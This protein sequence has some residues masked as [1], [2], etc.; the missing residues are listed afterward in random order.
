MRH[1]P[2]RPRRKLVLRQLEERLLFTAV[3]FLSPD[4]LDVGGDADGAQPESFD[5]ADDL[6]TEQLDADPA[7]EDVESLPAEALRREVVIVDSNVSDYAALLTQLGE[8]PSRELLLLVLDDRSD[9][10]DQI[11]SFLSGQSDLDA[12]H[13][14][15]HGNDAKLRLGDAIITSENL[16]AYAGSLAGWSGSLATDADILL[17]GCDVAATAAGQALAQSIAALT[18]ADVAASND[19]TGHLSL[20]GD[21]TLEY[22]TGS[23]EATIAPS[24]AAQ[25]AFMHVLAD[26]DPSVTVA[27]TGGTQPGASATINL[28][29]DNTGLP[30]DTGF[31]PFIDVLIPKL[32]ADGIY[33]GDLTGDASLY[34]LSDVAPA[35]GQ[36]DGQPDGLILPSGLTVTYQGLELT[37]FL[38]TFGDDD[39]VGAGTTGTIAHPYAVDSS[40]TPLNVVGQAGDQLLVIEL[41]FGSFAADQPVVDITIDAPISPLADLGTPLTVFA[42]GGFRYGNDALADPTSDPTLLSDAGT[43]PTTWTASDSVIP[44]SLLVTK[45]TTASGEGVT[46]PNWLQ[47]FTIDVDIPT[48]QMLSNFVLTDALPDN[49]QFSQI[50][51]VSVGGALNAG[52]NFTTNANDT[53]GTTNYYGQNEIAGGAGV[54]YDAALVGT[55]GTIDP[56]G[57]QAGK[58]LA[59]VADSG[60]TGYDGTDITVTVTYFVPDKDAAG[61]WVIGGNAANADK[62][63]DDPNSPEISNTATVTGSIAAVDARDTGGPVSENDTVTLDTKSISLQKSVSVVGGGSPA[64]GKLLEW[65]LSFELSDYYTY[66]NLVIDDL[67]SDGQAYFSDATNKASFSVTDRGGPP[68]FADFAFAYGSVAAAF[69]GTNTLVVDE[70]RHDIGDGGPG[71]PTAGEVDNTGSDGQT[72]I[73]IFLSEAL[74]ALGDDGILEGDLADNGVFDGQTATGTIT[75]YTEIQEEFIDPVAGQDRSVDQG[76]TLTNAATLTADNHVNR[77]DNVLMPASGHA[78]ADAAS[79]STTIPVGTLTKQLFAINGDTGISGELN[80]SAGDRVTYRLTYNLPTTDFEDLVLTDF[81]PLPVFDVADPDADGYSPLDPN[82]AWVFD[83][84]TSTTN[85]GA[86]VVE[87]L[88]SDTFYDV[89][90][91]ADGGGLDDSAAPTVSVDAS[92]NSLSV[93]FGTFDGTLNGQTQIDLLVTVT[94]GDT[95]FADGLFLT[96]MAL[97]GEASTSGSPSSNVDL[98]QIQLSAPELQITKGIVSTS[99]DGVAVYSTSAA[100]NELQVITGA[101]GGPF[102]LTF[103]GETTAAVSATA[104]AEEIRLALEGLSNV[105]AGDVIVTGSSIGSGSM[106]LAFIGQYEATDISLS[107]SDGGLTATQGI[108]GGSPITAA[109]QA[110]IWGLPGASANTGLIDAALLAALPLDND[111]E[112]LDA[113]DQIKY[114]VTVRNV[115]GGDAYDISITD[116]LPAGLE[117]AAGGLNLHVYDVAGN[118]LTWTALGADP[119]AD[120]IRINDPIAVYAW[121]DDGFDRLVTMDSR[122]NFDG[123][124]NAAFV[125]A[126]PSGIGSIEAMA[127][128]PSTGTLYGIDE[129]YLG[130]IDLTTGAFTPFADRIDTDIS[131]TISDAD[132][133]SFHPVTG[134]LWAVDSSG[135]ELVKIDVTTGKAIVGAFGGVDSLT[136][137]G[138]GLDDIA[139]DF[140]GTIFASSASVLEILTVDESTGT[141]TRSPVGNFMYGATSLDDMEGISVDQ[142]GRL[143]GTTGNNDSSTYDDR[144]WEI[145][146]ATGA[147]SNPRALSAGGDFESVVAF[148][149]NASGSATRAGYDRDTLVITYDLQLAASAEPVDEVTPGVLQLGQYDNDANLVAYS[150][151]D[152]GDDFVPNDAAAP[153]DSASVTMTDISLDTFI[154]DSSE[155]HTGLDALGQTEATIGEIIR[156]RVEMVLPEGTLADVTLRDVLPSGLTF[157]DDGTAEIAFVSDNDAITSTTIAD[158][159][160]FI[161]GN[162]TTIATITPVGTFGDEDVANSINGSTDTYNSGTDVYFKLGDIVNLDDDANVEYVVIEF[163]ALVNNSTVNNSGTSLTHQVRVYVDDVSHQLSIAG[164]DDRVRIVEP[165]LTLGHTTSTSSPDAGDII[166]V[167]STLVNVGGTYGANAFDVVFRDDLPAGFTRTGVITITDSLSNAVVA[168]VDSSST[169]QIALTFDQLIEGETYTITY[170]VVANTDI[171]P[172]TGYDFDADLTWTSLSGVDGTNP[173][174]TGSAT[175]GAAGSSTGERTGSESPALN[176]YHLTDTETVDT[177]SLVFTK[178]LIGTE[179]AND[180]DGDATDDQAVIGEIVTYRLQ[181][182]VPEGEATGLVIVDTLDAGLAFVGLT[183]VTV[184]DDLAHVGGAP[185]TSSSITTTVGGGGQSLTF[186]IGDVLDP[187]PISSNDIDEIWIEYQA[188][189][190]NVAGNQGAPSETNTLL[191]NSATLSY[192]TGS[193][194]TV[195]AL[196]VEVIEPELTTTL[197]VYGSGGSGDTLIEAGEAI[198]AEYTIRNAS[199]VDAFDVYSFLDLIRVDDGSTGI[200]N[201]STPGTA[202]AFTVVDT[203]GFYNASHFEWVDPDNTA[204][205]GSDA[206]GWRLQ[207]INPDGFDLAGIDPARTITITVTGTASD[208]VDAGETYTTDVGASFTSIDGA[209]IDRSTYNTNSD[210]RSFDSTLTI[211]YDDYQA[212]SSSNITM[213]EPSISKTL[214]TT[215]INA[216]GNNHSQ[217]TIGELLTYTVEVTLPQGMTNN[218]VVTDVMD[219]GLS[220]VGMVSGLAP[221][222]VAADGKTLTWNL[223]TLTN[224]PAIGPDDTVTLVYQAVVLDVAAN[225]GG[226]QIG[227]SAA[228]QVTLDFDLPDSSPGPQ[229]SDDTS[230]QVVTVVEPT[231]TLTRDTYVNNT[232]GNT[233]GDAGDPVKFV[234]ELA[235]TSGV[236]AFDLQLADV[237]PIVIGGSS[238]AIISPTFTVTDTDLTYTSADFELVGSN[239]SGW[240]F[241]KK[242][243]TDFDLISSVTRTITI[244]ID[245]T[246]ANVVPGGG[247]ISDDATVTWTSLDGDFGGARSGYS[248]DSIERDGSDTEAG[249]PNDYER[250]RSDSVTVTAIPP[251]KIVQSTSLGSSG[252]GQHNVANEDLAIGETITYSLSYTFSEGLT[253]SA[254]LIDVAG[255]TTKLDILNVVVVGVGTNLYGAGVDLEDNGDDTLLSVAGVQSAVSITDSNTDTYLDTVTINLSNV[256]NTPDGVLDADDVIT[257]EVTARVA[258]DLVNADGAVLTNKAQFKFLDADSGFTTDRTLESATVSADVITHDLTLSKNIVETKADAGEQV[259]I[260]L[261]VQNTGTADAH[262]VDIRD[263]LASAAYDLTSVLLGVA[264]T[265][266]PA[267]FTANMNAGSGDLTYTGGT[268]AAGDTVTFT[269]LVDVADSAAPGDT[270]SNLSTITDSSSLTAAHADQAEARTQSDADGVDNSALD[271]T[272]SFA[273]RENTISGFVYH[274]ADMSDTFNAGDVGLAGVTMTLTGTDHL[275]NAITPIVITTASGAGVDPLGYYLFDKLRPGSYTLTQT[276]PATHLDGNET[277]G[278]AGTLAGASPVHDVLTFSLPTGTET[279]SLGNDFGEITKAVITGYVHRDTDLNGDYGGSGGIQDVTVTINY[280][281]DRNI[282]ASQSISTDADGRFVFGDLRPGTYT[283]TVDSGDA[284]LAGYLNGIERDDHNGADSTTDY[285]IGSFAVAQGESEDDKW[286]GFHLPTS[287]AGYVYHDEDNDGVKDVGELG[288]IGAQMRLTGTTFEGDVITAAFD[289]TDASGYYEFTNLMPGTYNVLEQIAPIG[290]LD[291]RDTAGDP[292]ANTTTAHLIN[293]IVLSDGEDSTG[294]LFGHVLASSLAGTVFNDFDSDGIQDAGEPGIESVTVTLSGN[295]ELPDGSTAAITPIIVSTAANGTYSFTNLRPGVYTITETQPA[296]YADGTDAAGTL[297]GNTAV[298]EVISSIVVTSDDHGAG[299]NFA[300]TGASITGT[301]FRDDDRDGTLDGGEPGI[302]GATIELYESDGTT[303]ITTTTTAA[304]GTY[305]FDDLAAGDYVVKEIQPTLYTSSPATDTNTRN[306]TLVTG[307]DNTGNNFGEELWDLDGRVWFDRD[308]GADNDAGEDGFDAVTVTLLYAGADGDLATSGDNVTYTTTT[309]SN[310]DYSFAELFN[311]NYRVTIDTDDLPDGVTNNVDPDGGIPSQSDFA[312][313]GADITNHDFGYLGIGVISDQLWL[314]VNGDGI[315]ESVTEPGLANVTV[316][317]LFAGDDGLFGGSDDMAWTDVTDG[318][319]NYDFSNLPDGNYRVYVD[320]ADTDLPAGMAAVTVGNSKS[321]TVNITLDAGDRIADDTDF[322]FVGQR[323][324]GDVFW[325]DADGDGVQDTGEPGLGGVTVQLQRTGPNGAFTVTTTTAA[326]GTYNFDKLPEGDYVVSATAGLPA[327]ATA[328]HD[329]DGT[330]DGT[331]NFTIGAANRTDIDFGYRGSGIDGATISN[332]VWYDHDGDGVQDGS[333]PGIEGATVTLLFAGADGTFGNADDFALSDTTDVNGLY[334]FTNLFVGDYRVSVS[335]LPTGMTQTYHQDDGFGTIVGVSEI[336]VIADQDRGDIDFGYTGSRNAGGQVWLDRNANDT[337][338]ETN[339][340]GIGGVTVEL[341]YAGGDGTFGTADDLVVNTT[342]DV[343]GNYAFNS[344]SDGDYRVTSIANLPAGTSPTSGGGAGPDGIV[345]F[346]IQWRERDRSRSRPCWRSHHWR[347]HLVRHRW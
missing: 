302:L 160:A 250:S 92:S 191:N 180:I 123:S 305:S 306:V 301:V 215:E 295:E 199:G 14:L 225:A 326:D 60:I 173:N 328:T 59:I 318:S 8:D 170:Q 188:I 91:A 7:V 232:P 163:N 45:S 89:W 80:I 178:T 48:G 242:A 323:S 256:Q 47:T 172:S 206:E 311:G 122:D 329:V 291:G 298:N 220:F 258:D 264:G 145:D 23:I 239:A 57:P 69:D 144:I 124:S 97:A 113:L 210:E 341:T 269:F 119:L 61:D 109:S 216:T 82:D 268:V 241:Q 125:G 31:G 231:V 213:S 203:A 251:T 88:A 43:D 18:G 115:G 95:Q 261:T 331:A 327:D 159:A 111:V 307:T 90:D 62:G 179:I 3:P 171:A 339:E 201:S 66:G 46:G 195:S 284:D 67:L 51:G 73:K 52:V 99:V 102:T 135:N 324:I 83:T 120:G 128:D 267:G 214:T 197:D 149:P 71:D 70:S 177:P 152:G 187:T 219:S 158:A 234:I 140:N 155:S 63:E 4:M 233:L 5:S 313:G 175:P 27:I 275:G 184:G 65:T 50:T 22:E 343:S 1:R 319:G 338:G 278:N 161:A 41:P 10:I 321:G 227:E 146:K 105:E 136:V 181:I 139:I 208:T 244:E 237:L 221:T 143:W 309:D 169:S 132:A 78:E 35:D 249:S 226:T 76:D 211:P 308:A 245:G 205:M 116:L 15:S 38:L 230:D 283:V 186:D 194:I 167:T 64:P 182:D 316:H 330:D 344:L 16:A 252:T 320:S 137:P 93:D 325:F 293:N 240:T 322:G 274:D 345:D 276:Q 310:G 114:A 342:T 218:V 277:V 176:D 131:A 106:L 58:T 337:N 266:Y 153:S 255:T 288:L 166:T 138:G 126:A 185:I 272:D 200:Q 129:D 19:L 107:V 56:A 100:A 81:F 304:D 248:T 271:D 347:P 209:A 94:V 54:T 84:D 254:R 44:T 49:I 265:D 346:S 141:V 263:T 292:A 296:D 247:T 312:V 164:Q 279:D 198:T 253:R 290:Y 39:G 183:S 103:E 75:F 286:F 148:D 162:D 21:W 238:S 289:T 257:I 190:L 204:S 151:V 217:A 243:A 24:A 196:N 207:I 299:Y 154:V 229:K 228:S 33:D 86:G 11:D 110:A 281:D 300:E 2:D 117:V 236:D 26:A 25:S 79:A 259:T 315:Y 165:A 104:T 202:P 142:D 340:P 336:S 333:E 282:G 87:V 156:Y 222:T 36:A 294:N 270:H 72:G 127:L 98:T 37:S 55:Y 303:L 28:S 332:F 68:L 314:D 189:V 285:V 335:N 42:R 334:A 280:T 134:E 235:N 74:K 224:D 262:Q 193:D 168:D 157:L 17:Y 96:N 273:V 317:I 9:S 246:L 112:G 34:D 108:A 77:V 6:P 130:T 174:T 150:S 133:M 29:F 32:G 30:G 12:I 147:V 192:D 118:E 20:G 40:G 287:I 212:T 13:I 121:A 85:M 260:V 297:G 101:A 53:D 223:G